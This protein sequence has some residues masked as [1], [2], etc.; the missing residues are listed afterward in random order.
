MAPAAYCCE[1]L[2]LCD[3]NVKNMMVGPAM[4]LEGFF[5]VEPWMLDSCYLVSFSFV[6][7]CE[8]LFLRVLVCRALFFVLITV[9]PCLALAFYLALTL[10]HF[11]IG[12]PPL[13]ACLRRSSSSS[14][15][16]FLFKVC[17]CA[18]YRD[19]LSTFGGRGI[20]WPTT[21]ISSSDEGVAPCTCKCPH[22]KN[23]TACASVFHMQVNIK[24]LASVSHS[25]CQDV[26]LPQKAPHTVRTQQFCTKEKSATPWISPHPITAL[27]WS[28]MALWNALSI[29]KTKNNLTCPFS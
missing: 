17:F 12:S 23:S 6:V 24:R 26:G 9:L 14:S 27:V 28:L 5:S 8:M 22:A 15:T 1:S 20:P 3:L 4:A 7:K 11:T 2:V 29:C 18:A 16:P 10:Q 21:G 19:V 25:T 13:S